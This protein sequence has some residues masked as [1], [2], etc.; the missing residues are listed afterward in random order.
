MT[1]DT[2]TTGLT[3]LYGTLSGDGTLMGYL[4]GVFQDF[5]PDGTL[6][7]WCVI[8]VQSP[9]Q[10]TLTANAVR[11]LSRPLFMVKMVGPAAHMA[12]LSTAYQ[13]A[14]TLLKLVRNTGGLL[15][16]YRES[17]FYMPEI[18]NGQPYANLG[19]LYRMVE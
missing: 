7:D 9:G 11:I 10:D 12:N 16:C 17:P 3:F 2:I 6:P 4:Q 5:A 1:S 8:G 15:A 13:R 18:V 19:G 14:D